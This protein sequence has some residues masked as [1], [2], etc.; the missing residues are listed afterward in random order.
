MAP[1]GVHNHQHSQFTSTAHLT[2]KAN[3]RTYNL[4]IICRTRPGPRWGA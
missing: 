3:R 2:G 1:K 4:K